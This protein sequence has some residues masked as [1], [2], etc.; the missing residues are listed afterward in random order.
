MFEAE[1]KAA[2]YTNANEVPAFKLSADVAYTDVCT[3][4]INQWNE[5]GLHVELEILD[6]P[7]LKSEIAK[8]NIEFFRASWIAD[9]PDPEN[10]LSLFYGPL[11][12][13]AGPNY[14]HYKN[15]F[16]DTGFVQSATEK[17]D[18]LRNIRFVRIEKMVMD[19]CPVIVLYY[20]E[21]VRFTNIRVKNL[22]P[23]PM[24]Y[25]DLRKVDL[26]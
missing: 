7:T 3:Y 1:I 15:K 25:L 4:V 10:Y 16:Y 6:R 20:D 8:G 21:V 19:A 11:E 26:N 18:S 24:N 2:G 17:N 9:Y 13:P 12:S 22:P 14:T 23:H 5:L